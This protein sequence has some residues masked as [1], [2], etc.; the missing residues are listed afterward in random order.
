MLVSA[1]ALA[2]LEDKGEEAVKEDGSGSS[3]ISKSGDHQGFFFLSAPAI[4]STTPSSPEEQ[5][6]A[7]AERTTTID[8]RHGGRRIESPNKD[9]F[10]KVQGSILVKLKLSMMTKSVYRS[11]SLALF[12]CAWLCSRVLNG[13]WGDWINLATVV[14]R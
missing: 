14:L 1:S 3:T 5:E 6:M 12:S 10:A 4:I 11:L 7:A 8:L 13:I 2:D 9:F